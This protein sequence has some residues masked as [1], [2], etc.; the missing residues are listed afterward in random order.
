M[1]R[2]GARATVGERS[3]PIDAVGGE[4]SESPA[5]T[6]RTRRPNSTGPSH[7]SSPL[8]HFPLACNFV[9]CYNKQT[10]PLARVEIQALVEARRAAALGDGA[11]DFR[12]GRLGQKRQCNQRERSEPI[13]GAGLREGAQGVFDH[14]VR[15]KPE[16]HFRVR[17]G[18]RRLGDGRQPTGAPCPRIATGSMAERPPRPPTRARADRPGVPSRGLPAASGGEATTKRAR[19]LQARSPRRSSRVRRA[20]FANVALTFRRSRRTRLDGPKLGAPP[21][22]QVHRRRPR[23]WDAARAR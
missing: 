9:C 20:A 11:G 3:R 5:R 19:N 18:G 7:T 4:R 8:A 16:T 6:P 2:P 12:V 22:E 17:N 10:T 15:G 23:A 13:G 14:D 1:A 21:S